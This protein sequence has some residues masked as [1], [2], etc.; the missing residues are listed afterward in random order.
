VERA[1]VGERRRQVLLCSRATL[2]LLL[3]AHTSMN[4]ICLKIDK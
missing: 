4:L 3:A 2:R 1:S